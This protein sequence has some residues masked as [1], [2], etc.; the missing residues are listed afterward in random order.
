M[1]TDT[2]EGG[3]WRGLGVQQIRSQIAQ[4]ICDLALLENEFKIR[5]LNFN[6]HIPH[7]QVHSHSLL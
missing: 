6:L 1:Y 3:Q 7:L 4:V 2:F 5:C